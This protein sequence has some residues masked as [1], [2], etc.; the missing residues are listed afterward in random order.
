MKNVRS[1][2]EDPIP[3]EWKEAVEFVQDTLQHTPDFRLTPAKELQ[4]PFIKLADLLRPED[5]PT[6]PGKTRRA[7]G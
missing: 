3:D 1:K 6:P 5:I 2:S 4:H 7:R